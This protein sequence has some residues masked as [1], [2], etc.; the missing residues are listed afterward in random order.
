MLFTVPELHDQKEKRASELSQ[1]VGSRE[2]TTYFHFSYIVQA[3]MQEK[4]ILF[5]D[6]I[7][8][9][10]NVNCSVFS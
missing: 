7:K 8:N 4:R 5:Y 3:E 1:N 10:Q 9:E 6:N 2:T